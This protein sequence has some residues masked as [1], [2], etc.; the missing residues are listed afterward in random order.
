MRGKV[1][2]QL[3]TDPLQLKFGKAM[4]FLRPGAMRSLALLGKIAL[5]S[6]A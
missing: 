6:A 1:G 4:A 2:S 5:R 3:L